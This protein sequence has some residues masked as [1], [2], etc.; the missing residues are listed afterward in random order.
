MAFNF[1]KAEVREQKMLSWASV[2][3]LVFISAFLWAP[4]RDGLQAVYV[5]AVLLPMLLVL[6]FRKPNFKEYGGW[7]TV[8]ALVYAGFSVASSLWST[9]PNVGFFIVQWIVL[10]AWLCGS[11]CL[12]S[13][14]NIDLEKYLGWLI[15]LGV[16]ISTITIIYY[17]GFEL[18]KSTMEV[19]LSGLNVFRN[20]NEIGAMCGVIAL[21]AYIKALQALLLKKAYFFHFLSAIAATGLIASFSRGALLGF[22]V[23]AFAA[24]IIIRPALKIWLPPILILCGT[25]FLLASLTDVAI[26][27]QG[28]GIEVGE[29]ADVWSEVLH[30]SQD[31]ILIGIGMTKDTTIIIPNVDT[32][33]HAHNAW[34]DTF[35]RTGLI[36]LA[37]VIIHL[38]LVFSNFSKKRNLLPLYLWLGYG[39]ICSLVDSRCFFW[40]IGAKWFLYWIPAGL[41]AAS[42][43]GIN[44]HKNRLSVDN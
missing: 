13:K 1:L 18:G 42:L 24:L 19:R 41:I 28:R 2:G 6:P 4:S 22:I 34:L 23:M 25:F 43:S 29:R 12:F 44:F 20:S 30:R 14:R 27:F 5:L 37:L 7:M 39:C 33:N 3:L 32:F 36:G 31:H 38:V 10:S 21:L 15:Y 40:E 16:I 35:Y 26:D 9:S 11:S 17:Y 8:S